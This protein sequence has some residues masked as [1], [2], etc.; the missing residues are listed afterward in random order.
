MDEPEFTVD[1]AAEE[2]TSLT[3]VK[4]Q[5]ELQRADPMQSGFMWYV[6]PLAVSRQHHETGGHD[7]VI[8]KCYVRVIVAR[9]TRGPRESCR[10]ENPFY[11]SVHEITQAHNCSLSFMLL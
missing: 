11:C 6:P 2:L 7:W 9:A 10:P 5:Q 4:D 8:C 1:F 3:G